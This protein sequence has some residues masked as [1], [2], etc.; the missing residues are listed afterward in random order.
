MEIATFSKKLTKAGFSGLVLHMKSN[1]VPNISITYFS[2]G[3]FRGAGADAPLLQ[4][5][6][7]LPPPPFGPPFGTF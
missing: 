6:D 4:G 1:L 5:F 7:S 2:R 3:G